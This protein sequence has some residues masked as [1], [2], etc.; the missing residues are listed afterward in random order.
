AKHLKKGPR[1]WNHGW[2]FIPD[3]LHGLTD[4]A[5]PRSSL[6]SANAQRRPGSPGAGHP[7]G[8][9]PASPA[10]H[11]TGEA[12]HADRRQNLPR[13]VTG[14]PTRTD[15]DDHPGAVADAP[16]RTARLAPLACPAHAGSARPD[17]SLRR[18]ES[19]RPADPP[20]R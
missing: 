2:V 7:P 14:A 1:V 20:E 16:T 6:R 4:P 12:R 15:A 9:R 3:R 11:R 19:P 17:D 5:R 10:L 8:A 18:N 13:A